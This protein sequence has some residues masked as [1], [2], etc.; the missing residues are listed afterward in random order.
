MKQPPKSMIVIMICVCFILSGCG[1]KGDPIV[2]VIPRPLPV[3]AL[4]ASVDREGITL[5]WEAPIEYDTEKTLELKDIKTFVI[6]RRTEAPMSKG[7]NF[8]TTNEGWS[9][10]G[11]N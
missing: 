2:P 3:Q 7:W 5:S 10:V 8:T 11:K 1:K 4:S 9:A 6:H